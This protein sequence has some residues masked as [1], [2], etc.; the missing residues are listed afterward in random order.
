MSQQIALQQEVIAVQVTGE[1][2]TVTVQ[3]EAIALELTG[4]GLQGPPG[5][6]GSGVTYQRSFG[7]VDLTIAGLLPV[8][9]SLGKY[10][11]SVLIWDSTGEIVLPDGVE[12]LTVNTLS[13]DLGS[14]L[15]LAGTWQIVV[16]G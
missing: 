2:V 11:A 9:H 15:P 6:S 12:Y 14:F 10:P 13:V 4:I 5:A 7:Q 3:P 1:E 16:G 8:T